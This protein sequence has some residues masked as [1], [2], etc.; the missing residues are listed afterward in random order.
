MVAEDVISVAD[1]DTALCSGPALR[2]GIMGQVLLNQLGGGQGGIE[3][4]FEQFAG[5]MTAW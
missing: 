1:V 4:I 5:P 2:W 3:H